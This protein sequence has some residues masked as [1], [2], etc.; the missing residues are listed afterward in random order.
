MPLIDL[1]KLTIPPV[2]KVPPPTAEDCERF[3]EQI[4]FASTR[5][6]DMPQVNWLGRIVCHLARRC[7]E[8]EGEVARKEKEI[9]GLFGVIRELKGEQGD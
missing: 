7:R 1:S 5:E 6:A 4:G 9:A 2:D 3:K 8:L